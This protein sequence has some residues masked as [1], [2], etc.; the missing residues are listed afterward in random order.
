MDKKIE[1]AQMKSL[2]YRP[3]NTINDTTIQTYEKENENLQKMI[4][5]YQHE[6]AALKLKLESSS[7]YDL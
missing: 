7:G 6:V 3:K 2:K 5:N 1:K 4:K